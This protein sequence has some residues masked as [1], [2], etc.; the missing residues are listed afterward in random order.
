VENLTVQIEI[1]S[2]SIATAGLKISDWSGPG[3]SGSAELM[4]TVVHK[5]GALLF[6]Q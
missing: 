4:Q 5:K 3:I 1:G 2:G 6:C